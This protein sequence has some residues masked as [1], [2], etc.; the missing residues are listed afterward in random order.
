MLVKAFLERLR[1]KYMNIDKHLEI[2][3]EIKDH[4]PYWHRFRDIDWYIFGGL[5]WKDNSRRK[6]THEAEWKRR[7]DF[8]DLIAAFCGRCKM[9]RKKLA[10]YVTNEFSDTAEGHVHFV[11][12]KNGLEHLTDRQCAETLE[13][14]W[15]NTLQAY[16]LETV[17][18][19]TAEVRPYDKTR[20]Y[21]GAKYC[22]KRDYNCHGEEW[23]RWDYLSKRLITIIREKH[24][25][26]ENNLLG[27]TD[28][29]CNN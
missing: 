11:I 16:D 20:L 23:E 9:R 28:I 19:G 2:E 13:H 15:K 26:L 21:P 18:I 8:N 3:E 12:A 5:S 10:Y 6:T 17:G 25:P 29:A 4:H 1:C 27:N 22:L 14:L 7:R 24:L